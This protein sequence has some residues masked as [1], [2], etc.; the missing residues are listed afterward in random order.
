[1]AT[2]PAKPVQISLDVEL[3][4]RIDDDVET[5][6]HGRSAFIRTAVEHY[7]RARHRALIDKAIGEAYDGQAEGMRREI[8][9]LM[10][11]QAW[12]AE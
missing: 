4:E 10:D 3:L 1:M 2:M 8:A 5:R 7:L 11:A 6:T 12:P 9:G